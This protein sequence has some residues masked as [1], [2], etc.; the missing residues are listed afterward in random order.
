MIDSDILE[1]LLRI[2]LCQRNAPNYRENVEFLELVFLQIIWLL[3]TLCCDT[4][5]TF[6]ENHWLLRVK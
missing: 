5:V 2:S 4:L 1:V 3:A 6:R